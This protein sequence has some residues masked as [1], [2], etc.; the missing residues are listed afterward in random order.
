MTF[1]FFVAQIESARPTFDG[2]VVGQRQLVIRLL[3]L[4]KKQRVINGDGGFGCQH[5]Q[6]LDPIGVGRKRFARQHFEY[7]QQMAFGQKRH[8]AVKTEPVGKIMFAVAAL[9]T[10][11]STRCRGH[12]LSLLR[13]LSRQ[14][15]AQALSLRSFFIGIETHLC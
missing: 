14:A 4:R 7:S 6:K 13:D 5:F 10:R 2:R 1:G 8:A 12:C 9:S 11:T 3:Q 15:F